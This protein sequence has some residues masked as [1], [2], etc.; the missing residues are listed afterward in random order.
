MPSRQSPAVQYFGSRIAAFA[1]SLCYAKITP[2]LLQRGDF[3]TRGRQDGEAVGRLP[4]SALSDSARA[5]ADA[6]ASIELMSSM[7]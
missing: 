3:Q 1:V 6:A 7:A 5:T 4:K 2:A